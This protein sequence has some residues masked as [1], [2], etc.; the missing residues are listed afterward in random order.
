MC[1]LYVGP[2][3]AA[4]AVRSSEKPQSGKLTIDAKEIQKTVDWRSRRHAERRVIRVLTVYGKAFYF[5]YKFKKHG[6]IYEA[7]HLFEEDLNKKL[8][9]AKTKKEKHLKV[10]VVFV[11]VG[12]DGAGAG[13]RQGQCCAASGRLLFIPERQKLV[14]FASP[15]YPNVSGVVLSG[16][17][18]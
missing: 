10:Q 1:T 13:C 5:T 3:H 8:A 4:D 12:R 14:D 6:I 9:A 2:V 15:T 17:L 11:P 18:A 7:F 16:P